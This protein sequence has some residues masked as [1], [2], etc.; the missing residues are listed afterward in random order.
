MLSALLVVATLAGFYGHPDLLQLDQD[1]A[2]LKKERATL[3]TFADMP[4]R[5]VV[6]RQIEQLERVRARAFAVIDARIQR[7][8]QTAPLTTPVVGT[9]PAHAGAVCLSA[10]DG[11]VGT[12]RRIEELRAL[13]REKRTWTDRNERDALE[14]EAK[15]LEDALLR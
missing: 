9:Q 6:D 4:K 5:D 14:R 10:A 11:V 3:R 1:I 8:L 7:C 15:E 2:A 13:A 12:V